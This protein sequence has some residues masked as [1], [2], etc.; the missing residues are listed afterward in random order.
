VKTP[1]I[2]DERLQKK[3]DKNAASVYPALLVLTTIVLI[4]KISLKLYPLLYLFEVVALIASLSYYAISTAWKNVL[5]MKGSDEAIIDIRNKAKSNSYILLAG[6]VFF[7]QVIFVG[8][9]N[10]FYRWIP[11]EQGFFAF[12]GAIIYIF[13]CLLPLSMAGYK[14]RK[15]EPLVLWNSE[16]SKR[17]TL[18]NFKVALILQTI[19]N[20][21]I[22]TVVYLFT[23]ST[24]VDAIVI[25]GILQFM[26][27]GLYFE[28]R[29]NLLN[30]EKKA[31][32]MI[33][34]S[35]KAAEEAKG[36]EE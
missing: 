13:I 28:I 22:Q 17:R 7:G 14:M 3:L 36:H 16:A 15:K 29:R 9:V 33:E 4:V 1:K 5:F 19:S 32:K 6:I 27:V 25:C 30:D 11:E 23:S 10:Y 18:K 26:W 31:N 35:E 21:V 8:I 34:L 2:K 20:V 12:F 24:L